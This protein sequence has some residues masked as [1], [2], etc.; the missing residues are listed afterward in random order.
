LQHIIKDGIGSNGIRGLAIDW[1]A[2]NL[3]FTNVFP[4]ENYLEVCWLD[5]T[6]RKVLVKTTADSPRELAVNPIK[7]IL[8][9]IDYGQY[10]RI[11]KAYLDGSGWQSLVTSGISNP[12]DLTIDMSTHD[13]YWV[14]SKLDM[15][16]KIS[17]SGGSRQVIR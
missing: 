15:I 13:V 4:H 11:G 8:Y 2:G 6:H 17:F 5:G 12:R 16:Q 7:R 14:D 3:Y 9:W 1:I 10:P